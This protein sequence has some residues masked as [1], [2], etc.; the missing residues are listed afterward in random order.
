[1]DQ[2]LQQQ[3]TL[4]PIGVTN[5]TEAITT[6]GATEADT[7]ADND[8][9]RESRQQELPKPSSL[10]TWDPSTPELSIQGPSTPNPSVV[11]GTIADRSIDRRSL[12]IQ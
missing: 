4:E 1:V 12:H 7:E 9:N 6:T 3:G 10:A 2:I 5:D 8:S 11:M